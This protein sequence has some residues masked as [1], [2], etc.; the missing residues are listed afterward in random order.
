MRTGDQDILLK[1]HGHHRFHSFYLY[2]KV[3]EEEILS[4]LRHAMKK[5][6]LER[7]AAAREAGFA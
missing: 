5:Q 7:D 1:G 2:T 4:L 6:I 3:D